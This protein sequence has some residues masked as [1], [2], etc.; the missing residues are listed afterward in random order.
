MNMKNELTL[1]AS[2]NQSEVYACVCKCEEVDSVESI[3]LIADEDEHGNNTWEV[4][5]YSLCS[6]A[7]VNA[8]V[9]KFVYRVLEGCNIAPY[10][11]K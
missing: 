1:V 2:L 4:T 5:Y 10:I 7:T 9:M 6:E 11:L 8:K 3:E